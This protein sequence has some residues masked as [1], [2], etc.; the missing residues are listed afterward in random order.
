MTHC[1]KSKCKLTPWHGRL[2]YTHWRESLGFVFNPQ[3]KVFV[4]AKKIA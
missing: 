4:K 2:C 3:L 1:A